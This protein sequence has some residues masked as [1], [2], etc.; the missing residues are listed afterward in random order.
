MKKIY[1]YIF[2]FF[3]IS[4][5]SA[6]RE[7]DELFDELPDLES[8]IVEKGDEAG[9]KI[10]KY[11]KQSSTNPVQGA[12]CYGDFLFQFQDHNAA[13]YIYDFKK[14]EYLGKTELNAKTLNHCNNVS[15]S[16]IFY[17]KGDEFPL[18]YVSGSGNGLY[19]QVQVYRIIN[20]NSLFSI[21]QIQEIIFPK[22][23]PDNDMYWTDVMIDPEDQIM[24][25]TTAASS[26]E[27]KVSI[28]DIPDVKSTEVKLSDKDILDS[29]YVSK[30]THHQGAN[31]HNGMLYIFEGVPQWGDT[32]Y[33]RIIDLNKKEDI[34]RINITEKGFKAE[35][36]GAFFYNEELYCATNNSGIF[37]FSLK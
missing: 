21:I 11:M 7:D 26:G 35:A 3:I 10:T 2:L 34:A 36:E 19:N 12:D 30:F 28:F 27:G 5:L 4:L 18:L 1:S 31:I 20:D 32:N 8:E 16:R 14:K 23:S 15:F 13:V 17:E 29:F 9:I 33:L 6:C 37:K 22:S 25:V 24:Y